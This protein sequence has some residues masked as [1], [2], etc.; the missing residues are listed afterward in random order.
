MTKPIILTEEQRK[1]LNKL[2]WI[3]GN[4]GKKCTLFN[5]KLIQGFLEASEDR[6][7][8]YIQGKINIIENRGQ[9]YADK[10]AITDECLYAVSKV[11]DSP[12]KKATE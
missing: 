4:S 6:R 9:E 8:D 3:Y 7:E 2:W 5:H 11:I 12:I 1:A 10:N